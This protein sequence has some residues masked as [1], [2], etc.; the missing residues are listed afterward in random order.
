MKILILKY[1]LIRTF[2]S[3]FL[4]ASAAL[5]SFSQSGDTTKA[6][7]QN[8][9]IGRCINLGNALEAPDIGEWGVI[10]EEEFFQ[11]I[12]EKGF[13]S[14]RVP[15]R[16]NAH[17]LTF[18]PYT[19][20]ESF[21]QVVDWVINN[22]LQNGLYVIINFHHYDELY[23]NPEGHRERFLA[24]WQQVG[25]RYAGYPDS[26][27]FEILN[28]PHDNLTVT[29][30]NSLLADAHAQIRA[31]NPD[32]TIVIGPAEW[33]G[34]GALNNLVMPENDDNLIL[35]VH[36]YNPFHFTHQG[37]GWVDGSDAWLGT[38]WRNTLAE[39]LQ[40]QAEMQGVVNYS[41]E[42]HIPVFMGEFGAY[43]AADMQSRIRWTNY[44]PRFFEEKGFSWAYWEFCSGFGI[45]SASSKSWYEGLL[46]ALL[47]MPMSTAIDAT[48]QG[49]P[50][51]LITNGDFS[52][53]TDFWYLYEN[54]NVDASFMVQ[55]GEAKISN[56]YGITQNSNIALVN[57]CLQLEYSK[58]YHVSFDAYASE[59]RSVEVNITQ[60][61]DPWEWTS[62]SG[63]K[64][65]SLTTEK[66]SYHFY[67]TMQSP[68]DPNGRFRINMGNSTSDVYL[69]NV[70]V[71][72]LGNF[73]DTTKHNG[74][75]L[76]KDMESETPLDSCEVSM[77]G[78]SWLTSSDG[79]VE[80]DS[81]PV[82]YQV[83]RVSKKHYNTLLKNNIAVYSDTS[84]VLSLT[85]RLY[86]DTVRIVDNKTF[87]PM[88]A[89]PVTINS[90]TKMTNQYGEV[91]FQLPYGTYE[92]ST[93]MEG[94]ENKH[95]VLHTISSDTLRIFKLLKTH[96]DIKFRLSVGI[97]PVNNADIIVG[98]DTLVTNNLG[99]AI[100]ENLLLFDTYPYRIEKYGLKT[101]HDTLFLNNDTTVSH[102]MEKTL[103]YIKFNILQDDNPIEDARIICNGDTSYTSTNGV[104]GFHN[105]PIGATYHY[106]IQKS[107]FLPVSGEVYAVAD[108][109]IIVSLSVTTVQDLAG[110]PTRL[111]P[112]P[113]GS[114]LRI[115]ADFPVKSIEIF[116]I[117]GNHLLRTNVNRQNSD[118]HIPFLEPG[119]YLVR[120]YKNDGSCEIF[121]FV[122]TE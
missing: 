93:D 72:D 11:L 113:A 97:Q 86:Q 102:L 77:M 69:D 28:E 101:I 121:R 9:R 60:G 120:I 78:Q 75:F 83:I 119:H 45:Y 6:M 98:N 70:V 100:F 29:K 61:I 44:I 79:I 47:H 116:D 95:H 31:S 50:G 2:F 41:Q 81:I 111:Y 38:K 73:K 117:T 76:V 59:N 55:N 25:N 15:I 99:I 30:W 118:I 32:R 43:S 35:T 107:G 122:K 24:M 7:I 109:N 13:N 88:S 8:A 87:I 1:S 12:A 106:N 66:T 108:T 23:E 68:T 22:S 53:S 42:N 96:A 85:K 37:A 115:E 56:D 40:V 80:I 51:N 49:D 26:L 36:Y 90:E 39:R 18:P 62:Y 74:I 67:F 71:E 21:F 91:I 112:N 17:A 3:L 103:I 5:H 54:Q 46:Y 19:I 89:V 33:G 105:L 65:F 82:G 27:I 63:I 10:L 20:Y 64:N 104:A 16:W 48:F 4:I 14:V 58:A 84:I 114:I 57:S 34:V 92:L 94:Y 110:Q 52:D